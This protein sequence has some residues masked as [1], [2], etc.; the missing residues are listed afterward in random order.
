MTM[1]YEG[2]GIT[3]PDNRKQIAPALTGFRNKI[4][5]GDFNFWFEG[6]SQTTNGYGSDTMW[7][8]Q[9]SG[10][11]KVHSRQEF[12]PGQ[13]DVPGNPTYFSRTVVSSV[14]GASNYCIKAQNL[15]Q[16]KNLSGKVVTLS[17]Y[18]KADSS[19]SI[20]V[21]FFQNFGLSGSTAIS[22]IGAQKILLST[23][24]KRYSVTVSIPSI[25]GKTIAGGNEYLAVALWFDAGSNYDSRTDSLGQQSGT[26]DI[27]QV[28][29]E[30]GSVATEF[31]ERSIGLELSLVARYY[32]ELVGSGIAFFN[33]A[34]IGPMTYQEMRAAPTITFYK[35]KGVSVGSVRNASDASTVAITNI[36]PLVSGSLKTGFAGVYSSSATAWATVGNGYD[37]F[38]TLNARL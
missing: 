19:K 18:A 37:Y 13:T 25:L 35:S 20:A 22:G 31:E 1:A 30:E 16:L 26:F 6:T 10:T 27:A 38:V 15:E 12:T 4:I 33:T 11:T 28:Q 34:M 7:A 21:E 32:Q 36:A 8:N 14:A 9:S 2:D 17:F 23:G 5:D 24:W 3:F 29:L